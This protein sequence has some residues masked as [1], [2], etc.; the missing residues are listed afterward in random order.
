M[1]DKK[2][3]AL[4]IICMTLCSALFGLSFIAIK[5][6]VNTV[7]PLTLL[8]WRF[9]LAF[10][11]LNLCALTGVIK[12]N[13]KGKNLKP[14]L[15]AAFFQ[16][17]LYYSCETVG[18]QFTTASESGTML[19]CVPIVTLILSSI[20]LKEKPFKSQ[21]AGIVISVIGVIMI[22][23][24][25]GA[26]AMFSP[27]GYLLLT[28]TMVADSAYLIV[29]RKTAEFTSAEKTYVIM[30]AGGGVFTIAAFIFHGVRGTVMDFVLA[31]FVNRQ[32]MWG[33]LYLVIV[34]SVL[35]FLIYNR[36]VALLPPTRVASFAGL[37]TVVT[38]VVGVLFLKEDF[39][40]M[41]GIGTVLVVVG[42]Y[43]AN[44]L[45]KRAVEISPQEFE[46]V[47]A[48]DGNNNEKMD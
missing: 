45:P 11:I 3:N 6:G 13:F 42:V 12:L 18:I 2:K 16:P 9:M 14:M 10:I 5:L 30:G 29:S 20:I 41:Q 1:D 8:A 38:V 33:L 43:I 48:Q 26:G 17:L 25:K 21:V 47:Q 37:S 32:F 4:G 35:G 15:L 34:A 31:P 19:A 7:D 40:L 28:I 24:V 39:T 23:I 22:C 44:R 27:V 46:A 36:G